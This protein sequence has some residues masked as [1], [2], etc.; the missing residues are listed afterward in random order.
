MLGNGSTGEQDPDHPRFMLRSHEPPMED[1]SQAG[2]RRFG[3]FGLVNPATDRP[4]VVPFYP[5]P[6]APRNDITIA[7]D[8]FDLEQKGPPEQDNDGDNDLPQGGQTHSGE[9][10]HLSGGQVLA[11]FDLGY[12]LGPQFEMQKRDLKAL[13][14]EYCARKKMAPLKR[15]RQLKEWPKYLRALDALEAGVRREQIAD[16]VFPLEDPDS[17]ANFVKQVDNLLYQ[18]KQMLKP[19]NYL[20]ILRP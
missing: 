13:Q 17:D 4:E 15:R 18:A 8:H 7:S 9:Y 10:V 20:K 14:E 2:A 16:V 19:E 5:G 3:I 11:R 12:V 1:P 6:G